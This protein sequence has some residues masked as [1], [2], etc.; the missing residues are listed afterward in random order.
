ME[1]AVAG[2]GEK[3]V[4]LQTEKTKKQRVQEFPDYCKGVNNMTYKIGLLEAD[5][6]QA[7]WM[8]NVLNRY[9]QNC[10]EFAYTMQH[11]SCGRDL[12]AHYEQDF[13]LLILGASY[14]I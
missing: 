4:R 6:E 14:R 11:Y 13:D 9:Q 1:K 5:Q 12:L 10:P 8:E 2:T 7:R 3:A